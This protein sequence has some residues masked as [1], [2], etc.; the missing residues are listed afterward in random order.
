MFLPA[1]CTRANNYIS[2]DTI[3]SPFMVPQARRWFRPRSIIPVQLRTMIIV[4]HRRDLWPRGFVSLGL[5]QQHLPLR[6][7]RQAT[8]HYSASRSPAD[9]NEFVPRVVD[10]LLI[11][12]ASTRVRKVAL[13]PQ[14]HV[15]H[16]HEDDKGS[17]PTSASQTR[18]D[19]GSRTGISVLWMERIGAN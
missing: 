9:N 10:P 15:Q 7:L 3:T 2:P 4:E 1:N 13:F 6:N 14:Q 17:S 8:G 18:A 5:Q 19:I 11:G 12:D 16:P